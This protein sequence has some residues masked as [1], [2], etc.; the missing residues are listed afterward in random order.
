MKTATEVLARID[1]QIE[2]MQADAVGPCI[3]ALLEWQDREAYRDAMR[4]AY[5]LK[6]V[7][8]LRQNLADEIELNGSAAEL[9]GKP[10]RRSGKRGG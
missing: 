7:I 4:R 6:A 2:K 9:A 8:A 1:A 10:R 3:D 5:G